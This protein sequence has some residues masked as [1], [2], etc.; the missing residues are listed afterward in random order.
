[1]ISFSMDKQLLVIISL[2]NKFLFFCTQS[3][4]YQT[5]FYFL[6][7]VHIFLIILSQFSMNLYLFFLLNIDGVFYFSLGHALLLCTWIFLAINTHLSYTILTL[8]RTIIIGNK[9]LFKFEDNKK[10]TLFFKKTNFSFP[11]I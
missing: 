2:S 4:S 5:I 10:Q 8:R 9:I 11:N 3:L 6:N 1:M 7:I